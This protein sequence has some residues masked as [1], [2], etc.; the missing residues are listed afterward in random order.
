MPAPC[1]RHPLYSVKGPAL[2][3]ASGYGNHAKTDDWNPMQSSD[4]PAPVKPSN[5]CQHGKPM[6]DDDD[7]DVS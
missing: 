1:K 6:L 4:I 5:L 2:G 7:E 3:R